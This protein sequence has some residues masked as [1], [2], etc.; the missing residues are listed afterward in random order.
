MS[1]T[2]GPIFEKSFRMMYADVFTIMLIFEKSY[3]NHTNS[4]NIVNMI[5]YINVNIMLGGMEVHLLCFLL[6]AVFVKVAVC[7]PLI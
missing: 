7:L 3:N 6:V 2:R 5:K 4:L 1:V